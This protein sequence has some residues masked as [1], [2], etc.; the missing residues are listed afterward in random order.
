MYLQLTF[1]DIHTIAAIKAAEKYEELAEGFKD[2]FS[3]INFYV[4]NPI[5]TISGIE[6]TLEL[7]LCADYKVASSEIHR[8]QLMIANLL[9]FLLM[10]MGL[11]NAT[12][13]HSCLWCTIDKANR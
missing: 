4:K 9:Q 5:I 11:K 3:A 6:Y 8:I 1:T 7:F 13:K 10:V 12:A 2:A